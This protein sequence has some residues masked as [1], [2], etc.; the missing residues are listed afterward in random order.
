MSRASLH[1]PLA[2]LILVIGTVAALFL[3]EVTTAVLLTATSAILAAAVVAVGE[4]AATSPAPAPPAPAPAETDLFKLKPFHML[5]DQDSR[6]ILGVTGMRIALANEAALVLLGRH[7]AGIDIRTAIRHPAVIDAL[8]QSSGALV[9]LIDFRRPG[10]H[11]QLSVT[12]LGGEQRL[13]MIE[14]RSAID[15]AE[16]MRSDFVANASHELRTPLAAIIGYVET[17][18]H[19]DPAEAEP[20][21]LRFLSIIDREARR[22]QQ[23]VADLIS[24]SRIEADRYRRPTERVDLTAL[25]RAAVADLGSGDA[26]RARD[27]EVTLVEAAPMAGDAAQLTQLVHNIIGNAMKYGRSGTPIG[28]QVAADPLGWRLSVTDQGDGI[29]P[30]HIPRLTERFYRVDDARS[31][32]VGGTGLGL[33]IV[34]HIAERHQGRLEID[35]EL[36][37]GTRVSV[38]FQ[39]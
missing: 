18:S 8:P 34:K 6:V 36:G 5:I 33:A 13:L 2:A 15:A 37:K 4:E 31:R 29:A 19:L 35:S 17:L 30:D 11:W 25:V 7:I 28:V 23:L 12:Q 1:L 10:D 24:I 9:H 21:R 32:A 3:T 16:R 14:D 26:P 39:A 38:L 22:M 27:I 20:V